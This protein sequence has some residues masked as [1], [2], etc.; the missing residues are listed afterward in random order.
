[1]EVME[2]AHLTDEIMKEIWEE[3]EEIKMKASIKFRV[4][5]KILYA[6]GWDLFGSSAVFRDLLSQDDVIWD[7]DNQFI[8]LPV[9]DLPGEDYWNMLILFYILHGF[10]TVSPWNAYNMIPL[11]HKYKCYPSMARSENFICDSPEKFFKS[12]E[13]IQKMSSIAEMYDLANLKEKCLE[14]FCL[15]NRIEMEAGDA[16]DEVLKKIL[17]GT[18]NVKKDSNNLTV[19]FRV[20]GKILYAIREFLCLCSGVFRNLLGEYDNLCND[21]LIIELLEK[22]YWGMFIFFY[23]LNVERFVS[24]WNV[25][26]IIPLFRKYECDINL[27][28]S[29]RHICNLPGEFFKTAE[30]T[31]KMLSLAEMYLEKMKEKCLELLCIENIS[32]SEA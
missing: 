25:Y 21:G 5:G 12:A 32:I 24:P 15:Y 20:Q 17:E 4:Q 31:M 22:D 18:K 10:H 27:M 13:D 26:T 9:I 2:A 6:I 23:V 14:I 30:D 7:D 8:D 16:K 1:M 19:K 28:V 29:E 3:V 11:F